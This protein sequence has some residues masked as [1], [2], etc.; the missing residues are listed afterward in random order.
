MGK[1]P[2]SFV[3]G[4]TAIVGGTGAVGAVGTVGAGL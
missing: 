4:D 3:A 1:T 2:K